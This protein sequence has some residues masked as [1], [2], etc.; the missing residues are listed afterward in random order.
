MQTQ[1]VVLLALLGLTAAQKL[2]LFDM[3]SNPPAATKE[4]SEKLALPANYK[5]SGSLSDWYTQQTWLMQES[6][7][8]EF[9]VLQR[10]QK[11]TTETW[12]LDL[13]SAVKEF[14]YVNTSTVGS[15]NGNAQA[16]VLFNGTSFKDIIGEDTSSVKAIIDGL[17]TYSTKTKGFLMPNKVDVVGG[18]NVNTWI[19]CIKTNNTNIYVEVR[20][21]GDD[22]L[23]PAVSGF[24]NPLLLSLRL[25]EVVSF[26]TTLSKNHWSIELDQYENPTG[27]EGLIPHGVYCEKKNPITLQLRPLE[28]YAAT[29]S[30]VDYRQNLTE[31]VDVLYSKSRQVFIIAGNSFTHILT[32]DGNRFTNLTD[33]VLH[34][35]KYGYEVTMSREAC[36]S[37]QALQGGTNDV[38]NNSTYLSMAPMVHILVNRNW[39]WVHHQNDTDMAGNQHITYRSFDVK[40]NTVSELHVTTDLEIHSMNTYLPGTRQLIKTMTVTPIP[41]ELSRLNIKSAQLSDCYDSEHYPNNTWIV[42]IKDKTL[43]DLGKVGLNRLN[44][45]V[46]NSITKNVHAVIPYR[47]VVFYVENQDSGI[48][49]ILRL[50]EK[51]TVKPGNVTGYN[52]TAELPTVELFKMISNSMKSEK[53]PIEVETIGGVKEE[54]V[55]DAK[56]MKMFPDDNGFVGYTGGAM[57]VLAIF[58]LLIGVSIGAVGLFVVTRRQRI[59]TLAYQVF[60]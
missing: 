17:I 47:V 22:S 60:E 42:P 34:D 48:S 5:V 26:N 2:P 10:Q 51:T 24:S 49:M 43:T 39:Q 13:K 29:L 58:C 6:A 11:D 53:M 12:I 3:C 16:P 55:A 50:A 19:S 57:F 25:A 8:S 32:P 44:E 9:R 7:T 21:A 14:T 45:A 37:F 23:T 20:Y 41:M 18:I 1:L 4:L 28:E 36:E 33:Y 52:Y 15:C 27:N 46:V 31:V 30:F 59:S 35:F 38:I 40:S 54:W 56:S